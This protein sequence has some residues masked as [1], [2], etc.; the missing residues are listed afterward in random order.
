M[1]VTDILKKYKSSF[2]LRVFLALALPL[3]IFIP[4]TGY[5]GYLQA[6]KAAKDQAEQYATGT[7]EQVSKRITSYLARHDNTALF[8]ASTLASGLVNTT[9]KNRLLDYFA[10]LHRSQPNLISIYF[11]DDKGGVTSYPVQPPEQVIVPDPKKLD[12]AN[13]ET[14]TTTFW[15]DIHRLSTTNSPGLY[16]SAPV[17][18]SDNRLVGI[19]GIDVNLDVLADFLQKIDISIRGI[20]YIFENTSGKII[21]PATFAGQ[22]LKQE[23]RLALLEKSRQQLTKAHTEFGLT[24]F[25]DEQYFTAY[26]SYPGKNWTVGVTFSTSDY[27]TKVQIIKN[28]TITLVIIGIL[29]SSLL[30]YL[31]SKNITGPLLKLQQGID[32][33]GRGDLEH[34]VEINDPD[35]ARELAASFNKM[36]LSLQKSLEEVKTTYRELQEQQ[37]LAAVGSMTAGIAH[38]IKNPL[39]IILGSTQVLLDKQR[40]WEMREK[41]ASFIMDEVVRLDDTLKAFLAFAKPAPPVF[42]EIDV[43]I[44][45]EETLSAVEEKYLQE[46]YTIERRIPRNLPLIEADPGQI[47]QILMNILLNGLEAMPGGGKVSIMI[48]SEKEPDVIGAK[49][50][51]ISIRNPFT[52]DRDWLIVSIRD[53]GRG[54]SGEQL[55]K[56]MDPFIS[57][58]DDGTGLGLSIVSQLVKLH[59]GQIQ[60]ESVIGE[61]TTFHLY[62]P[63]ILKEPTP[64]V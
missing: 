30:S 11:S 45:L 20:A 2:Q 44:L 17:Y 61:G 41:A 35:I 64:N 48:K 31:L 21:T 42:S 9:D 14:G 10:R 5:I 27:L 59:R 47:R 23:E 25:K 22:R 53:E 40:P 24:T 58:R 50:R 16:I 43:G 46:G 19:C 13:G 57:F 32:R 51:F 60:V 38:E 37:K 34:R 33:I 4:G 62:F 28:T 8:L 29:L 15:S 56:I 7:V 39:G 63:C 6:H 49:K 1:T 55:E 18:D 52:V 36:A 3:I 26:T 54:M 12:R